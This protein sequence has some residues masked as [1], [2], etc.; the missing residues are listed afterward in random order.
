MV[1]ILYGTETSPPVR[2]VLLTLRAMQLDYTFHQLDMQSGEHLDP[3]YLQKNPQ[4]TIPMLEDDGGKYIW[5]SHAICGYLVNQYGQQPDGDLLYPK[6]PLQRAVVDQRLHFESGILFHTCFKQLQKLVFRENVTELP[7]EQI[8]ELNEAYALLEQF[9][10]DHSFMAGDHLTIADFS[11]VSTLSTL[12][13]SYAPIQASKYPKLSSWL[14]RL[15][16][17]PYYEEANLRGARQ[18]AD[19]VRAKLPKQF[20]KL[21]QKAFEDIK[22]G[23]GKQ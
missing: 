16:A 14:G 1:L 3:A 21:W 4:H 22:S 5:D 11:L 15:S 13:L 19:R 12:H 17:L 8:V 10:N 23:A 18:L 9:L 6:E 20:D 2:A 7:K